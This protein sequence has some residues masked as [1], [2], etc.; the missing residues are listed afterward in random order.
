VYR[1]GGPVPAAAAAAA[2]AAGGG[3]LRARMGSSS[4]FGGMFWPVKP[5][6]AANRFPGLLS[7]TR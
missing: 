1:G 3:W 6:A 2:A 4:I 7:L 5:V